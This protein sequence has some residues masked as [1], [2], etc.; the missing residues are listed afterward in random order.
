MDRDRCLISASY[1]GIKVII[2][3]SCES[4]CDD[5]VTYCM[6]YMHDRL[7]IEN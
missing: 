1:L 3:H 6:D 7:H 2:V 5:C 4:L